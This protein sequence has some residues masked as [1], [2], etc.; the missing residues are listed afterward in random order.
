VRSVSTT[1]CCGGLVLIFTTAIHAKDIII[2]IAMTPPTTPPT[3]GPTGTD[4]LTAKALVVE[5]S[6]NAGGPPKVL[7]EVVVLG[8]MIDF[9]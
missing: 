3:I 9:D 1:C 4:D 8:G 7:V 6:G 2:A 5:D